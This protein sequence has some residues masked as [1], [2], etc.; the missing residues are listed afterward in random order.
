MQHKLKEI[1]EEWDGLIMELV[2]LRQEVADLKKP[3][4]ENEPDLD[5]FHQLRNK[6][7]KDAPHGRKEPG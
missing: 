4:A 1:V 5:F 2:R 7:I 6:A 3:K